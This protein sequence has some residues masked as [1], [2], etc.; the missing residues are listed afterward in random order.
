MSHLYFEKHLVQA[1]RTDGLKV[2][3]F[4]VLDLHTLPPSIGVAVDDDSARKVDS[5]LHQGINCVLSIVC[6]AHRGKLSELI[7]E[8][9]KSV[10]A[11]VADARED[12]S[13]I[14][15]RLTSF[16]SKSVRLEINVYVNL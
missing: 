3:E 1:V 7:Y 4:V 10:Q 16:D 6:D 14:K 11:Q 12:M 13:S 8:V 15:V 2:N 9:L 5:V